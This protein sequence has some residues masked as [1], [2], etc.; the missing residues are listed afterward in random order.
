MKEITIK[1]PDNFTPEQ[2][3]F[4]K[5]SA[6][7]QIE[8]EMQKVLVVPQKDIDAVKVKTEEIKVAM[9]LA[10]LVKDSYTLEVK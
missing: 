6:Y 3:E 8:A 7:L 10:E 2:E 9:G 5:K 4:I 1:I